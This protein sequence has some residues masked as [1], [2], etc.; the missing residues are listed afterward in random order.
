MR[1]L[2]PI[3]VQVLVILFLVE[4]AMSLLTDLEW[5]EYKDRYKKHYTSDDKYHRELLDRRIQAVVEHNRLYSQGKVG[6]RMGIT[7]FSDTDQGIL[8]SFRSVQPSPPEPNVGE[9]TVEKP[10]GY[11]Q[12][13]QITEGIDWRQYG[14]ISEVENQGTECLS[15]WAFSAS[16]ALEAHL[17]KK[18]SRLVPLSAKHLVDCVPYQNQGCKG[19]WVSLAFKYIRDHGI[20]TKYAY[21]YDL[22]QGHCLWKSILPSKFFCVYVTLNNYDERELAEVVY[23]IGP[24]AVSIDHLHEEFIQY[25]AGILS[26]PTCRSERSKLRHSV[27]VVGFG[28]DAMGND[29]WLIKNSY[30]T[31]WGENGYLRLA[32]NANN[33]CGVASLPQYPLV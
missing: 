5:D 25:S 12:Y 20:S 13:D 10:P 17:A 18:H 23:N 14:Y 32:R 33:M 27:L 26:I 16:G 29:Y 24:V 22:K 28:T 21:P 8:F 11:K 15:C 30:G 7:E 2:Q 19:G 1:T 31:E 3:L 4:L 6:F 9:T